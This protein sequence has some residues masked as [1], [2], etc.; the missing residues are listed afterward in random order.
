MLLSDNN[1]RNT[2]Q[3]YPTYADGFMS[4]WT[5]YFPAQD[6]EGMDFFGKYKAQQ[7]WVVIKIGRIKA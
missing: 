4:L 5:L 6:S 2:L 1:F 7:K 3:Q